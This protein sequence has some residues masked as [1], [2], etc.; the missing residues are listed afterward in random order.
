MKLQLIGT[1]FYNSILK[2]HICYLYL[3]QWRLSYCVSLGN[4]SC[5]HGVQEAYL[6][7]FGTQL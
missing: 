1:F 2:F 3:V 6:I 4:K 5:L 7:K